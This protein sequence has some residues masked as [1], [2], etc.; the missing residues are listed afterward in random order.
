VVADLAEV[1]FKGRHA[2]TF[3]DPLA[4][5]VLFAPDLCRYRTGLVT[6][7]TKSETLAG[8]TSFRPQESEAPHRVAVGVDPEAFFQHYFSVVGGEQGMG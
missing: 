2:I 5:A 8:L 7:E 6:V 1:W 4:A 3:H